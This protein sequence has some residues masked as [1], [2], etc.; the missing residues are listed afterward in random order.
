MIRRPDFA[1]LVELTDR[2]AP[3]PNISHVLFDFDGTLSLIREGWPDVMASMFLEMLPATDDETDHVRRTMLLD[4]IALLT[5]KQTIYQMIRFAERVAERGGAPADPLWYKREY[6]RRLD[7]RIRDRKEDLRTGRI[8]PDEL[9][10]IGARSLLAHLRDLGLPLY[11]ASGTDEPY[12]REEA[13]LLRIAEFFGSRIYGAVDD[14]ATFSK[15]I[16]I[17]RILDENRI[18]GTRLLCFGDGYVEI[19]N[20]VAAGGLAVAVA[21]DEANRDSGRMNE[22]KRQR[23]LGVGAAVAIP[24]FRDGIAL[25]DLI[26]NRR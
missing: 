26:L 14:Y 20:T 4:D 19:E 12:V 13:D 21:T 5:G 2:F 3:R 18:E 7:E 17:D 15:K 9:M 10:V 25:V 1:G 22:W 16:V 24:D 23:L 11:L 6:L 8:E